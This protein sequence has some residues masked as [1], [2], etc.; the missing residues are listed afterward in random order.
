MSPAERARQIAVVLT[1][2]QFGLGLRTDDV[3]AMGRQPHTGWRGNL[4]SDD[5]ILVELALEQ[6]GAS[7]LAGRFIDDLS[8]GEKQRVMIARAIAQSPKLM[9]LDEITAF[10]DLPGRV[11]TMLLLKEYAVEKGA[12]VIL[13]SHDLELSLQLA[14]TIWLL[15]G[16]GCCIAGSPESVQETGAIGK[17]FDTDKVGYSASLGRFE[18]LSEPG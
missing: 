6:A 16:S 18:L 3:V 11:A 13:S 15:D 14:D 10:L 9:L 1:E 12:V 8:D 4:S 5:F 2:R 7:H 17:V